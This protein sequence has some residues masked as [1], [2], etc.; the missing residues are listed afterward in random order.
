[1]AAELM[2]KRVTA[3][4]GQYN[5]SFVHEFKVFIGELRDF[6]NAGGHQSRTLS[7]PWL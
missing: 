4:P 7:V 6:F 5:D 2:L 3:S 1:M